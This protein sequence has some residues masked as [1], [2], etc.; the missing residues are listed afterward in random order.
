M[1]FCVDGLRYGPDL[2]VVAGMATMPTRTNTF[3]AALRSILPQV[4]KIYI[5]L[6]GFEVIPP[7]AQHEKI[8]V[9][10]SQDVG[11]LKANGKLYGLIQT[12]GIKAYYVCVD[13]DI[14]YPPDFVLILREQL[15]KYKGRAVVGVHGSV[16]HSEVNTYRKDREVYHR[17]QALERDREVDVLGTDGILFRSDSL[18]FDVRKWGL[19][20]MVDLNFAIECERLGFKRISVKRSNNWIKHLDQQQPDSIYVQLMKNDEQQTRLAKELLSLSQSK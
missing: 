19:T 4:D 13:D 10:R 16:L 14:L 7:E 15:A 6:D 20:N 11:D 9:A 3:K 8:F 1:N 18:W 5:F 12:R 2:L 17:R